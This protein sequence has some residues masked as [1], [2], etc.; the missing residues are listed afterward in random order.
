MP[1]YW[2][3]ST[4]SIVRSGR[5]LHQPRQLAG[6]QS[7]MQDRLFGG[8]VWKGLL[9]RVPRR[10]RCDAHGVPLDLAMGSG[11]RGAVARMICVMCDRL[12]CGLEALQ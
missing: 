8:R 10:Q 3:C 5:M 1:R 9:L 12:S 11:K 7:C 4:C 2:T 6:G